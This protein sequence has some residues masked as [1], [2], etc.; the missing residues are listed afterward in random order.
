MKIFLL[1]SLL[2]K[3]KIFSHY[4]NILRV[5][6]TSLHAAN[7]VKYRVGSNLITRAVCILR[8]NNIVFCTR[9]NMSITYLTVRKTYCIFVI[10]LLFTPPC[11]LLSSRKTALNLRSQHSGEV[12]MTRDS[13]FPQQKVNNDLC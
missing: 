8:K 2:D 7:S 6:T 5:C 10:C 1:A 13:V 11:P 9:S 4:T 12:V 3:A